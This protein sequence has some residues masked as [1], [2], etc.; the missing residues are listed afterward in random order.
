M[1]Q[2]THRPDARRFVHVFDD[3]SE[4]YV[5]YEPPR[6]GV[7]DFSYIYMPPQ[8]RGGGR[9]MDLLRQS[10]DHAEQQGW[11]IRPTCPV[12][13]GRMMPRMPE[14]QHLLAE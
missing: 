8:H 1:L 10:L 12:I 6:Q 11:R 3:G 9:A 2:V 14:Y 13:A 5:Q 4:A 7:T